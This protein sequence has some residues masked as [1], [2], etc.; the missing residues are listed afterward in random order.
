MAP[1]GE[2]F[3]LQVANPLV[4]CFETWEQVVSIVSLEEPKSTQ[5][6]KP[7]MAFSTRQ[8]V[9]RVKPKSNTNENHSRSFS[10]STVVIEC[11]SISEPR[12]LF[13][14]ANDNS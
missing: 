13:N 14:G 1:S 11:Q 8:S 12:T 9:I 10:L 3:H 4:V 6:D 7:F 2:T 5:T